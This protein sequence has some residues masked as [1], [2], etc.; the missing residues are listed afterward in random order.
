MLANLLEAVIKNLGYEALHKVDPNEQEVKGPHRL[1][2]NEKLHQAAIPA[3]LTAFSLFAVTGKGYEKIM[4]SVLKE[5]HPDIFGGKQQ[6]I[7]EKIAEYSDTTTDKAKEV[8]AG[9]VLEA[10]RIVQEEKDKGVSMDKIKNSLDDQRQTIL[11]YLPASLQLG[12][13]LED[14][15]MDDRTHKMKGPMSDLAHMFEKKLPGGEKPPE[16]KA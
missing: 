13:L 16:K 2:A 1:S 7:A 4:N 8:M 12:E 3:A 10:M 15:S 9:V 11:Q 14:G 5:Q 6:G